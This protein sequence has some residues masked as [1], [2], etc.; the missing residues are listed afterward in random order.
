VIPGGPYTVFL[1]TNELDLAVDGG[2][3]IHGI[4]AAWTSVTADPGLPR[5]G[6]YA[7]AEID[8]ASDFRRRWLKPTLHATYG[9]LAAKPR[10]IAIGHHRGKGRESTRIIGRGHEVTVREALLRGHAPP[11][12]NVPMLGVLQAEIRARSMRLANALMSEGVNVL[13]IHAD[14]LHV[15]GALPLVDDSWSIEPRDQLEYL[16]RVS[17]LSDQGDTL[18]GRDVRERVEARRHRANL[19]TLARNPLPPDWWRDYCDVQ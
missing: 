9:L 19:V 1:W 5:Y 7:E 6:A 12:N 10:N 4:T 3:I 16:D 15:A 8:Q 17:W 14:G 13:H 11:T 2:L 18:P